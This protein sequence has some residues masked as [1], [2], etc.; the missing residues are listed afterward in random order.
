MKPKIAVEEPW[1]LYQNLVDEIFGKGV[2]VIKDLPS[3]CIIGTLKYLDDYIVFKDCFRRRLERLKLRFENTPSYPAL[4]EQVKQVAD[5]NNWE[6]AY[7]ELVAYD[8]MWNE[9]LVG[10]IDLD[11]TLPA[12]ES[13]AGEM[14]Q[15]AT[16]EDGHIDEYDLYFDVKI[17]SDT[18][19]AILAGIVDQAIAESSQS[20]HC[21]ILPEYPLDDDDEDYSGANRHKLF[22]ELKDFLISNNTRTSGTA[23]YISKVLPQL[24]YRV[25]WGGGVNTS[26]SGYNP[27]RHAEQT[28]HLIFKRYT[29]KIMK[30]NTF[31]LVMVN[32]PWYNNKVN[33]F[34]DADWTYYRSL[35]RRT[36]CAYKNNYTLMSSVVPKFQGKETV[37]EV[38]RHLAGIIFIDDYSINED[39]YSCHIVMNPNAINP[40]PIMDAYMLSLA[41]DGDKRSIYD[42]LKYD[43]Y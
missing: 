2:V 31:M 3:S 18:V 8:V 34:A 4:L 41:A 40:R 12:S 27:Y 15:K 17:L 33:S 9:C 39:S 20:A 16:N 23:S 30:N 13:F 42:D 24:T 1:V 5:P 32:F 28:R 37:Y 29:K 10:G 21:S 7:A 11:V 35:A 25:Q 19:G 36:F 26:T 43:N 38:S 14:G 22:C 6:G